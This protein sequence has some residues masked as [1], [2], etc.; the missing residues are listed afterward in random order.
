MKIAIPL[1]NGVL[2]AHFGHCEQFAVV[3]ANTETKEIVETTLHTPPAHEP[4]VL[5]KWLSEMGVHVILAGGM[6]GRAQQLFNA[7]GVEVV[8]G[9]P[10]N[11]PEQLVKSYLEGNLVCGP[12]ACDH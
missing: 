9:A 6:G 4:G 8:T 12:N 11:A 7:S 3:E 1:Y 10:E 2:S 5:P